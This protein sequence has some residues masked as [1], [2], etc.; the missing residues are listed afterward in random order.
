MSE[1]Q[2]SDNRVQ[3]RTTKVGILCGHKK[4]TGIRGFF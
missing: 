4:E 2:T 3:G 1:I